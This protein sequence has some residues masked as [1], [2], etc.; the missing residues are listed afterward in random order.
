M[1]ALCS[2]SL[3]LNQSCGAGH[4]ISEKHLGNLGSSLDFVSS[5]CVVSPFVYRRFLYFPASQQYRSFKS[6]ISV[7]PLRSSALNNN[8]I[9][10]QC[11][12]ILIIR[13]EI[14]HHLS[15]ISVNFFK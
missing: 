6:C 5:L 10:K 2:F 4:E 15:L 12:K 1:L 13:A 14:F 7:V 11:T 9:I 3:D 8:I